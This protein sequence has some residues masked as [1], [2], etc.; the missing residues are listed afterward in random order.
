MASA[1]ATEPPAES[2]DTSGHDLAEC[3]IAVARDRDRGAFA[4]LFRHFA[5]RVKSYLS[6]H[7]AGPDVAEDLAQETLLAVWHKAGLF[8]PAKAGAATWVFTIARNLRI[9]AMRRER[10]PSALRDLP[11]VPGLADG[12]ERTAQAERERLVALAL[13]DLPTE[14]AELVRLSYFEDKSHTDIERRL[15]LP[16][17]TVKSRLRLAMRRLRLAL[18]DQA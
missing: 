16:L 1:K 18:G 6:K 17:G 11:P 7:G 9:D 2:P 13:G 15:G 5:P 12:D 10:H 4:V 8:D 14:Q 3:I